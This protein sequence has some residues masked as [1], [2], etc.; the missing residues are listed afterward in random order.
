MLSFFSRISIA[1][2]SKSAKHVSQA[3]NPGLSNSLHFFVS[4]KICI[5]SVCGTLY[6]AVIKK[7]PA[8]DR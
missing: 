8:R 6:L 7:G 5:K 1:K 2:T 4:G 3:Q